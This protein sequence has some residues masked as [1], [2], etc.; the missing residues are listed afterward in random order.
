MLVR[1]GKQAL[2]GK[3]EALC[4]STNRCTIPGYVV[5]PDYVLVIDKYCLSN[6]LGNS[7]GLQWEHS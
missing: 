7:L 6:A 4:A 3:I 2:V 1:D 5:L